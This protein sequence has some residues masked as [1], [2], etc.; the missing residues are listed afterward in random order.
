MNILIF[1]HFIIIIKKF[2][3]NLKKVKV[4]ELK[5]EGNIKFN[6]TSNMG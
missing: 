2:L 6:N 3:Y 1:I 4:K 5:G